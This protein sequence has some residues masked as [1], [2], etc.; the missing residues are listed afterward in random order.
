LDALTLYQVV[1]TVRAIAKRSASH[2]VGPRSEQMSG[3]DIFCS[4]APIRLSV[5]VAAALWA[6]APALGTTY[7][8][9]NQGTDANDGKSPERS[10]RTLSRVNSFPL[11]PGDAVLFRRGDAWRGQLVPHSGSEAGPITYGAYGS[12]PK[13][14]LMGSVQKNRREDWRSE[15][16]NIWSTP[17]PAAESREVLPNPSFSGDSSQWA[18][19]TENGASAKGSRDA[20]DFDSPP[21]SYRLQCSK[22]GK[23]TCN[24]QL[25]TGPF[26]LA[27]ARL[28]RLRF[29]AKC[30][31]PCALGWPRLMKSAPPWTPYSPDGHVG[32]IR[33]DKAWK[34]YELFYLVDTAADDARLTFFLGGSVPEGAT[35]S[36]DSL[37]LVLCADDNVLVRDVG[38]VIFDGE[39]SCGR[40]KFE[41][42]QLKVQGDYW[43]DEDTHILKLYSV[44]CPAEQ[45]TDIEC[46]LRRHIIDQSNVHHVIYENLCLKYGAA[47]GVGGANTHH[48]IARDC[49]LAYIGG[50]DQMGGDRTVRFGNGIEFWANAHDHLVERC[51]LW[52]IY[53]AALT[54]QNNAP[55]QKQYNIVYRNNLIWNSEYSFEYWNRPENSETFNI[56]FENNT[57]VN[58]GHGW[59]HSQRP[60]P[61][62][63][64]LCFYAS[65]AQA[66]NIAIRNNIFF[67]AKGNAFYAP[68]WTR[69]AIDALVM[70][71][72]CWYQAVENMI[73]LLKDKGYP[74]SR[75]AAYQAEQGKESHSIVADP[76][77]TDLTKPDFHL[78]PNSPCIDTGSDL[79]RRCDF[80]GRPVPQGKAP[81]IGAYEFTPK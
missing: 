12:G 77:L 11:A 62:G 33:P 43:Y 30:S 36:L 39:A 19:H 80:E 49:D 34:T 23:D 7:Y 15:R 75:F 10:W 5:L 24:I 22:H 65:P 73:L 40:K 4:H 54:N 53:D 45:Y 57:C 59:G 70:D 67:E 68:G 66:R 55:R 32:Q 60:D 17:E 8:V 9:C 18:L 48:M 37:S 47:H 35:F 76:R 27:P 44:K 21:A 3:H 16:G 69:Q 14:L 31:V 71:N 63:R 61:S 29:R 38:N 26:T 81:D 2:V 1:A 42:S 64:H 74:M 58:A 13:P 56:R 25:Y 52:E 78:K 41:P 6:P 51:R 72:N 28:Y 79:E 20:A 46:A 50:G